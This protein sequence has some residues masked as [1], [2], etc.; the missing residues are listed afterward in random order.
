MPADAN[1]GGGP[2]T[3]TSPTGTFITSVSTNSFTLS[4][5]PTASGTSLLLPALANLQASGIGGVQIVSGGGNPAT[6]PGAVPYTAADVGKILTVAQG[7]GTFS[8]GSNSFVDGDGLTTATSLTPNTENYA[9]PNVTAAQLM[10]TQVTDGA[11]TGVELLTPGTYQAYS[12]VL[13]GDQTYV[14]PTFTGSVSGTTLTVSSFTSGTDA[15]FTNGF[16]LVVGQTVSGLGIPAGT[17]IVA[18]GTGTGGTGTYVL[19]AAGTQP[20]F[21]GSIS[22]TTL[23]VTAAANGTLAVGET[24]SGPGVMPGTTITVRPRASRNGGVGTY[25]VN[26]SQNV[27]SESMT[28]SSDSITAQTTT[29]FTGSISANT[30]TVTSPSGS[31]LVVGDVIIA[32]GVPVGTAITKQLTG[33]TGGGRHLPAGHAD[34]RLPECFQ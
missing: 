6:E 16:D 13:P 15:P 4:I 1:G 12:P 3:G 29:S 14:I 34:R 31:P 2:G 32:P 27:A 25:T 30:L 11:I 26:L 21:T 18:Q 24:I 23:T 33:A 8:I 9:N 22:G 7:Q 5:A 20:S 19:S 17:T 28:V 10:I